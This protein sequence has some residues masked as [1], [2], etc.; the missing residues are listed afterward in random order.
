MREMLPNEHGSPVSLAVGDTTVIEREFQLRPFWNRSMLGA[1][2]FVQHVP[3]HA[4]LQAACL[5]R[6]EQKGR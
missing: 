5:S 1:V 4:V 6:L 3:T 2:A